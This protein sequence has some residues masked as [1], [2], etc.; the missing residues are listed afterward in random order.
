MVSVPTSSCGSGQSLMNLLQK[1]QVMH[2]LLG[3][4]DEYKISRGSILMMQ[5]L[6]GLNQVYRLFLQEEKQRECQ[7]NIGLKLIFCCTC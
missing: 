5:L 4:N 3:L 6:P 7:I 2:F 1:Q